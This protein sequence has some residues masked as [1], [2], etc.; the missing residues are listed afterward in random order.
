MCGGNYCC[1][2]AAAFTS[3]DGPCLTGSCCSLCAQYSGE[4]VGTD[5]CSAVAGDPCMSISAPLNGQLGDCGDELEHGATCQP[6]CNS[7][8]VASGITTCAFGTLALTACE[9]GTC[10]ENEHVSSNACVACPPGTT[11]AAG[12]DIAGEDTECV[13]TDLAELQ[14]EEAGTCKENEHVSSNACVACPPG[15]TRSAGDDI[16]GEDTECVATDLAELQSK[17]AVAVESRDAMLSGIGNEMTRKKAKLLA[18]AIIAGAVVTKVSMNLRAASEDDACD[19]AFENMSLDASLGACDISLA[20]RRRRLAQT[21]YDYDYDVSVFLSAA[22]VDETV[23]SAAMSALQ[24]EGVTATRTETDP[25]IELRAVPGIDPNALATFETD[26]AAATEASSAANDVAEALAA[27]TSAPSLPFPP[28]SPP[29]PPP[30]APPP[31]RLVADYDSSATRSS[32]DSS[33]TI[34]L[35]VVASFA[36]LRSAGA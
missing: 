13:A 33:T 1:D 15:T 8:F 21:S 17:I 7:G 18:D 4:C 5:S 28:V 35:M 23:M 34:L 9:I 2:E 29:S 20:S 6:T 14:S 12:D 22:T 16:A 27:N 10:Q 26:A 3:C 24:T 11:R 25:I 30:P 19:V 32:F 31:N 36:T